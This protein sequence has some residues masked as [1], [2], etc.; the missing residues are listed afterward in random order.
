M[1]FPPA[2]GLTWP[3]QPISA[4]SHL[5]SSLFNFPTC[6]VHKSVWYQQKISISRDTSWTCHSLVVF[7]S[8]L[9]FFDKW[10][11]SHMHSEC[12]TMPCR[13][14]AFHFIS[15]LR[16]FDDEQQKSRLSRPVKCILII[17]DGWQMIIMLSSFIFIPRVGIECQR[18][19]C[20]CFCR[21]HFV[22]FF[23][24]QFRS[25]T[26][27]VVLNIS[28]LFFCFLAGP[29]PRPIGALREITISV[30]RVELT[31]DSCDDDIASALE[32]QKNSQRAKRRW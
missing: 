12:H 2:V 16:L 15:P 8:L 10:V 14:A 30:A 28:Q 19:C 22:L 6:I 32:S 1:I 25:V 11:S 17:S 4:R 27:V 29:H 7:I 23:W 9:F 18:S 13:V 26:C 21:L 20:F 24:S 31:F 5:M 3:D